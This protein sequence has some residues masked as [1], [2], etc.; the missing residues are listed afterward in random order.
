MNR[1]NNGKSSQ[2]HIMWETGK[3]LVGFQELKFPFP[4]SPLQLINLLI[5]N[6]FLSNPYWEFPV[7]TAV[8]LLSNKLLVL[9]YVTLTHAQ[10]SIQQ[11][12]RKQEAASAPRHRNKKHTEVI[13]HHQHL[14]QLTSNANQE[15]N[16]II[17]H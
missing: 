16:N 3:N 14:L 15:L 4:P 11:L 10:S 7:Y 12:P 13:L 6:N 1:K 5:K 2:I 8:T 9:K 17:R